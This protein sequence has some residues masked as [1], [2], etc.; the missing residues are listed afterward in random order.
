MELLERE[1]QLEHLGVHLRPQRCLQLGQDAALLRDQRRPV[2]GVEPPREKQLQQEVEPDLAGVAY[3]GLEPAVEL[4]P[5]C[6]RNAVHLS[7]RTASRSPPG[8]R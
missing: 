4:I 3:R 5:A 6:L 7:R 1:Q 2:C 8:S